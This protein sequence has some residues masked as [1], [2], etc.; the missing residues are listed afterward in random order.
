MWCSDDGH[1]HTEGLIKVY[2]SFLS[3]L[4]K[5][6]RWQNGHINRIYCSKD[7]QGHI[8]TPIMDVNSLQFGGGGGMQEQTKNVSLSSFAHLAN[9]EQGLKSPFSSD[10]N[11]ETEGNLGYKL[12]PIWIRC[13]SFTCISAHSADAW[14]VIN[15]FVLS[16]VTVQWRQILLGSY[17]PMHFNNPDRQRTCRENIKQCSQQSN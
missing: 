2:M 17:L 6:S 13:V 3:M 8:I 12:S 14:W 9:I 7:P 5:Y 10:I 16:L 15:Y 11:L 4:T 1:R